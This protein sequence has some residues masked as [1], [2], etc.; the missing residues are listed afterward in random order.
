MT[1]AWYR[2]ALVDGDDVRLAVA[3]GAH[4]GEALATAVARVGRGR[5]VWPVAAALAAPG[6]VPLGDSVGKGVVVERGPATGVHR[7]HFPRGVIAALDEHGR[8]AAVSAGMQARDHQ[9]T[10]VLE[11]MAEG[12]RARECFLDVVERLPTADNVEV[13]LADHYDGADRDEVWLTPRLRDLRKALR[14]LDD[15]DVDLLDSGHVDV[16]VYV[17]EPRSTWRLTQHKTLVLLT[18]DAALR[19]KVEG[20]LGAHGLSR[21]EALTPVSAVP[22]L[23]YRPADSSDRAKLRKRLERAGLR[24][25]ATIKDG[26]S[27][28]V[29]PPR[30][31]G[32]K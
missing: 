31:R 20:W 14:F 13:R 8:S 4:L 19:P 11:A 23:H 29:A 16:S 5:A 9:G 6:E 3:P 17:R 28:P 12:P 18:D 15:F 10:A 32:A 27:T 21:S 7:F 2:I 25:V 24:A 22:H 26:V 30:Q 1:A